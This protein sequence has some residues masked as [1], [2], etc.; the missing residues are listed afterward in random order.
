MEGKFSYFDSKDYCRFHA[1]AI[2]PTDSYKYVGFL[3]LNDVEKYKRENYENLGTLFFPG[4]ES[5]INK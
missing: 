3:L 4:N 1:I 2:V 5:F